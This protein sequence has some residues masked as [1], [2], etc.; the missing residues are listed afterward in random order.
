[1]LSSRSPSQRGD[2]VTPLRDPRTRYRPRER[3][4]GTQYR[5]VRHIGAGGHGEVYEVEH[6]FLRARAVMKLLHETLVE[7]KDLAKRMTRE[8]RTLA[9]LEHPNLVEVHDGGITGEEV[10][11]PYFVM[12]ALTGLSVRAL[13]ERVRGGVGA[14]PALR[15][16][17]SVLDGLHHA[18]RAGVI[19]RDIKP[20]NVFLHRTR[21]EVTV[22]KVLDF[23]VAHLLLRSNATGRAFLGTPRYAAPEQIRGAVPNEAA[24]VYAA[25]LVLFELL[26]GT[27]PFADLYRITELARA[28]E[29]GPT[30]R[31]T[32]HAPDLPPDVDALVALLC[33]KDPA[34]RPPNAFAAAIA[35][36]DVRARLE[37]REAASVHA[38]DFRTEPSPIE[39]AL[40]RA[41]G[42]LPALHTEAPASVTATVSRNTRAAPIPSSRTMRM[43]HALPT[44]PAT[45]LSG[46]ALPGAG[47]GPDTCDTLASADHQASPVPQA[48]PTAPCVDRA[49][50]TLTA[51]H[52]FPRALAANDTHVTAPE[53]MNTAASAHAAFATTAP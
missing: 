48:R 43:Q 16:L 40:F 2:G 39:D 8:A 5:F 21:E 27:P 46:F 32:A 17:A 41:T 23:G 36:R 4:P 34:A 30:P 3:I 50:I 19:H 7:R 52:A 33:A 44:V 10:P 24:D 18:H 6:D 9:R 35:V 28:H 15:V 37:A 51:L 26:T 14:L 20:D 1:M 53:P 45:P 38:P 31:P 13:L 47:S 22:P 49:A 11:R 25:G 42:E 29:V 12:E